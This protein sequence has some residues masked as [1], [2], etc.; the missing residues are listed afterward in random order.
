MLDCKT[1]PP[2]G[3][4]LLGILYFILGY[5]LFAVL[6]VA[7]GAVSPNSREG[8]SLALLYTLLGFVP[9]W[10]ASLLMLT[11]RSPIWIVLSIFPITAPV[12][13]MLRL[14]L[15]EIPV[16]QICVSV[17]VMALSIV[18]GLWLAVRIF[19]A[20]LLETGS[21]PGLAEIVRNLRDQ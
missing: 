1:R 21:R 4:I 10:L 18:G 13:T 15:M 11:P 7:V 16:W 2:F 3:I 20:H 19:R 9:L 17:A 6:S 12:Q 8:Q 5:L 14:G